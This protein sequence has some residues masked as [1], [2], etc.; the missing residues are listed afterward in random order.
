MKPREFFNLVEEMRNAQQSYFAV[1]KFGDQIA[2]KQ[3]LQYSIELERRVDDEIIR[4][5]EILRAHSINNQ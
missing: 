5:K 3:A 2:I 4:V 1:R